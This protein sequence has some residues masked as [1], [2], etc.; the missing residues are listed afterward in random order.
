MVSE[1]NK[2]LLEEMLDLMVNDSENLERTLKH[3]T[4]DCVWV[5]EP[6][7]T[8]YRG[9]EQLR[10]YIGIA[11]SGRTHDKD[12]HRI[13]IVGAFGDE[14]NLCIEYTHG[15]VATGKLTGGYKT[16][17]KTGILRYCITYHI[18]EGRFDRVHE[19]INSTSTAYNVLLPLL[20][21]RLYRQ[22]MKKLAS[23]KSMD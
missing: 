8:E 15:M 3:F 18:R 12:S 4:E 7:G 21:G 5:M 14:E 10:T 1:L 6:G 13:E 23:V 11:M 9:M 20:L 17:V 16:R 2:P 22:T 19:Y